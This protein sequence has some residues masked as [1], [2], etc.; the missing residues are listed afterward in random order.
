[1]G[2][3]QAVVFDLYGTLIYLAHETRLYARLFADLGLKAPEEFRQARRI[4]LSEDFDNLSGL[5]KRIRPDAQVNLEQ[6][7]HELR[8]EM[9]SAT[10]YPET[11][12]VLEE[13]KKRNLKLG[14]ISNLAS[15]YEE[16]FFR[17]GL[18]DYFYEELFSCKAGLIKPDQRIYRRM[19]IALGIDPSQTLMIG[20]QIYA[21][22]DGPKSIEMNAI[23][24][25]RTGNSSGS[26]S[27]LDEV[28][29]YL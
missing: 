18:N 1:M 26:I 28:F 9:A 13:L 20:D 4:A 11:R 19:I 17:L 10:L 8:E 21:D 25:D 6:Y 15:P 16:P 24:L 2:G 27:S 5:V 3:I 12:S 14:L 22:V 29:R 23:F 7:Q